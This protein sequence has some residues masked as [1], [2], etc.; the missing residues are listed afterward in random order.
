MSDILLTYQPPF[1]DVGQGRFDYKLGSRGLSQIIEIIIWKP[2]DVARGQRDSGMLKMS[3]SRFRL[4][5][6][7]TPGEI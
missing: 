5:Q 2:Q 1:N 4:K 7:F 6:K 3:V